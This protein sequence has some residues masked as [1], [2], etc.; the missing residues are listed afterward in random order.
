[1]ASAES[2]TATT[3]GGPGWTTWIVVAL[4]VYLLARF[5]PPAPGL[6]ASGQAVLGT[7]LCGMLLWMSE[8]APLGVIALVMLALL[9]IVP[10]MGPAVIFSGFSSPVLF[11]LIGILCLG[12]AV[13][14]T[15][16]A[17][18]V[19][20]RLV[21]GARGSPT[22]MYFQMFV[23][24]MAMAFIVPSA[25]TRNAILIP[26]YQEALAAMD[27][28]ASQRAARAF[29]L[30]LGV[31]HPMAS[32]ALLT[33]G[34]TS[35]TAATLLGGISWFRWFALM[36]VPYYL[37]L[38]LGGVLLW[39]MA[40]G[41]EPGMP[42]SQGYV[43]AESLSSA[44]QRALGVLLLTSGLWFTDA[45]HG[46][47]PSIPA[48]LAAALL[49]AP[50][51]GVLSWKEFEERISWGLVLTV[52]TSLSLAQALAD[53]G[54][55]TWLGRLMVRT[56]TSIGHHPLIMLIVLIVLV[57]VIHLAVTNL[58]ACVALLVPL[59][60]GF[61]TEAGLNPLL[62]GLIVTISVDA[63]ILYPVQTATNIMAYETGYYDAADVRWFGLAMLVLTMA[64]ILGVVLPYWQVLG[65][66]LT[67]Q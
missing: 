49:L 46:L 57:A 1:M 24:L 33:G 32:S 62:C 14:R 52:G 7:V 26:A 10:G 37:L 34:I 56:L 53:S 31:L 61:A 6:T 47:S 23:G 19:G 39:A 54:A 63:V 25:I 29:M 36:A 8:A 66:A 22:R 5:F 27:S 40:G 20:R 60:T 16:L 50:G 51:T 43:K 35:M 18:R 28:H 58:A 44:E 3:G 15:G 59:A 65:L 12:V 21:V 17:S 13:E 30:T 64:V 2:N 55:A 45:L 67:S 42:A 4:A 11:F 48:L 41:F 38:L 9:G